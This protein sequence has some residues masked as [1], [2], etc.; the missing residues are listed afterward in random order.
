M[1]RL[2]REDKE[3]IVREKFEKL[4]RE[5]TNK[6]MGEGSKPK[7]YKIFSVCYSMPIWLLVFFLVLFFFCSND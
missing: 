2:Y 1:L 7:R 5:Y 4:Y 6:P 3:K